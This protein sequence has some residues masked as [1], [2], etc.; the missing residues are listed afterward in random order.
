M[1][2]LSPGGYGV[3]PWRERVVRLFGDED[4]ECW[5]ASLTRVAVEAERR[6]AIL[7]SPPNPPADD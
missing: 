5:M 3:T 4:Y 2:Y 6:A 1:G 7:L